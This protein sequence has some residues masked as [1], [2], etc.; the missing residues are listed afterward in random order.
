MIDATIIYIYTLPVLTYI[1]LS[2]PVKKFW[3]IRCLSQEGRSHKKNHSIDYGNFVLLTFNWKIN[4]FFISG[5]SFIWATV[6][7][8]LSCWCW[9]SAPA[10]GDASPLDLHQ[11]VLLVVFSSQL[12]L[13]LWTG[14]LFWKW[15]AIKSNIGGLENTIQYPSVT[16]ITHGESYYSPVCLCD[17]DPDYGKYSVFRIS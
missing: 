1:K 9:L 17:R 13:W 4:Y 3:P 12:M 7:S 5:V 16:H 8:S 6:N 15:D 14:I 2:P 10:T 11:T